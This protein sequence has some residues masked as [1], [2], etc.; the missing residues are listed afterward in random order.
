MKSFAFLEA[1]SFAAA[2][3]AAVESGNA[4]VKGAGTDLL[5]LMKS[6]IVTPDHVVSLLGAGVTE[7]RGELSALAT[8]HDIATDEWIGLEFPA[9]R[10]AAAEAAT[11]Q[12]RHVGTLG[13]NLAQSTRCWYF[14]T[15]GHD[16][17]KLGSARCAAA[18][19]RAEN[20]YHGLFPAGGC[21]AAHPS[22]LAPA[23]IALKAQVDCVHPD[24]NRSMDAELLY[25]GA[26]PGGIADTCL[27]PG[28]IIRAVR[29]TPS[30]LA[31]KSVYLEVRERQ[32]FDFALASVAAAAEIR[33]GKVA[34]IRIVCG[35][36]APTPRRLVAVEEKLTGNRLDP[37][38]ADLAATGA[39]PQAQNRY[40]IPILK[41]LVRRALEELGR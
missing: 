9:L 15:P 11:P 7:K 6:R 28:E 25:D 1:D 24:G 33:D 30:P 8:L 3:K 29:L 2:S 27:R 41:R 19:E 35:G 21:C 23:L 14:R 5:D 20:R 10:T 38:A 39:E 37:A 26:K 17:L 31:R 18:D 12:V 40:K 32:S 16:C 22:N 4:V 36:V 13:G 34:E